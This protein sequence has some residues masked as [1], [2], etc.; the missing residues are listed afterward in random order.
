MRHVFQDRSV[1]SPHRANNYFKVLAVG[2]A[3]TVATAYIYHF[4]SSDAE[5]AHLAYSR[6]TARAEET[7][8]V[9]SVYSRT[10][11][12]A[13]FGGLRE[14]GEVDAAM[15]VEEAPKRGPGRPRKNPSVPSV[16]DLREH[17]R[18]TA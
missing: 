14:I 2:T 18:G 11:A 3:T 12:V 8:G 4:Y 17:F 13:V 10:G 9:V 15:A 5:E 16:E 7:R 1:Q 6:A